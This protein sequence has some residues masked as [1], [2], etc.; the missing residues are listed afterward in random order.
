MDKEEFHWVSGVLRGWFSAKL[1]SKI[2]VPFFGFLIF[3]VLDFLGSG[4]W[5]L[6]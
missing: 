2:R 6:F 1:G 5:E 4:F 3:W